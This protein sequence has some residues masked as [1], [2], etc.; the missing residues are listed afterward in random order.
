MYDRRNNVGNSN[1]YL[2]ELHAIFLGGTYHLKILGETSHEKA[3]NDSKRE[4]ERERE[5]VSE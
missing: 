5:R 4:R 2:N 3:E 1:S